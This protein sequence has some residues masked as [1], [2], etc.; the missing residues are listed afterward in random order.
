MTNNSAN[1]SPIHIEAMTGPRLHKHI[2]ALAKLR[3]TVFREFPYLYDGD[4]A[5]EEN[6]LRTYIESP[7]SLIVLIFDGQKVVGASTGLPMAHEEE[8]FKQPF[9]AH[10]YDPEKIFYFGESVLLP[11]YRG[12]GLGVKFFEEREKYARSLGRFELCTF[13][14]VVRP[15]DHPR[16]PADY[17]PLDGFWERRG[18]TKHSELQTTYTWQDL[19]EEVETPKPMVFWLK[20]LS[21]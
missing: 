8:N 6:Y 13:C 19:D 20:Q 21:V 7:E 17:Q 4:M 3:L 14:A 2:P 18:Y 16:R 12:R 15:E 10:G 1:K 5:Y 9:V 11:D